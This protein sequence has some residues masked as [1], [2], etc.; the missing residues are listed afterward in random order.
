MHRW[1]YT[2]KILDIQSLP[3]KTQKEMS[4]NHKTLR[5]CCVWRDK[6]MIRNSEQKIVLLRSYRMKN[7]INQQVNKPPLAAKQIETRHD[8]YS[9]WSFITSCDRLC[10]LLYSLVVN[11][12]VF[13]DGCDCLPITSKIRSTG[14]RSGDLAFY[15][16]TSYPWIQR[17]ENYMVS[18]RALSWWQMVPGNFTA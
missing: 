11:L 12:L 14:K 9:V 15:G 18:V 3:K 6:Q 4:Y 2:L 5:V 8:I 13:Q 16:G 10:L 7:V 17:W 1:I